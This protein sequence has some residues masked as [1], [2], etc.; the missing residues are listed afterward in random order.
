MKWSGKRVLIT[1][2]GGFIGSH[3]TE[4]LVRLG[5]EVA[6]F[7]HYNS[8][9]T[10]G[11]LTGSEIAQDLEV[12]AGDV[13]DH[14]SVQN[15][16]RGREVIF[17]L[18]ALIGIPYS[19]RATASYIRTNIE[20]T[21]NVLQAAREVGTEHLVHTSTSEVYGSARYIPIDE[22]HPLQAQSPYAATKMSADKMVEAFVNSFGLPATIVRPFN[23]YGPRQSL[24]AVIPT[25]ITQCLASASVRLGNTR[26]T[27]DFNFVRDTAAGFVRVA[28]NRPDAYEVINL[29]TGREVSIAEVTDIIAR[30]LE[31]DVTIEEDPERVRAST[32]EVDRLCADTSK[33]RDLLSWAPE[34]DLETGLRETVA[35]YRDNLALYPT[36]RYAI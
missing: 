22:G 25:I 18:A 4:S 33:A 34:T 14:E 29:G 17:H 5:A 10:W 13:G 7:T 27:R 28:E 31:M 23:T 1:G 16:V 6:A 32:S 8:A 35:W 20:G 15:A 3:L 21:F 2:A 9:G 24:R 11:W 26:P 12:I 36:G 30:I 19:Y